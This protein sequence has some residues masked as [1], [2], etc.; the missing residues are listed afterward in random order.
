[1]Q[2]QDCCTYLVFDPEIC[3]LCQKKQSKYHVFFLIE[4]TRE[5]RLGS[6]ETYDS[7]CSSLKNA[8]DFAISMN[9]RGIVTRADQALFEQVEV[10]QNIHKAGKLLFTYGLDNSDINKVIAQKEIGVHAVITDNFKK[11]KAKKES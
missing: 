9:F 10:I 5:I 4:S 11:I 8:L 3:I 2:V 6:R 1:M 7:R